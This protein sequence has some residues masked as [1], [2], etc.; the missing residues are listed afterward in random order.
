[1]SVIKSLP[2]FYLDV[3]ACVITTSRERQILEQHLNEFEIAK[4]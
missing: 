2:D 4:R 1:M 3:S